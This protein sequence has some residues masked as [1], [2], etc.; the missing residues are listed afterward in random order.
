MPA[1]RNRLHAMAWPIRNRIPSA[2]PALHQVLNSV[3]RPALRTRRSHSRMMLL[4][5][6]AAVFQYR[7]LGKGMRTQSFESP[8]RTTS[9]LLRAANSITIAAK[10]TIRPVNEARRDAPRPPDPPPPKSRPSGG[11]GGPFMMSDVAE[12][13]ITPLSQG[14]HYAS[15]P[16]RSPNDLYRVSLHDI[17]LARPRHAVFVSTVVDYRMHTTEIVK[18]RR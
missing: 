2:V 11:A 15:Q 16:G 4:A 7:I 8:R 6:S 14:H 12:P 17:I 1:A 9:A 3:R 5:A 10:K 18:R 13:A